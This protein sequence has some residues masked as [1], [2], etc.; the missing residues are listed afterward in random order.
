MAIYHCSAKIISR[1]SG[2]SATGAAAYRAGM[3]ITDERTGLVHDYSRKG[4]VDDSLILAPDHAPSWVHDRAQLWNQVEQAEKRK[5]AQVAREVEVALP[6][7]LSP[8]QMRELVTGY[9]RSQFVDK[10]MIADVNIHHAKSDNPHAHILLTTREISPDGF[11]Q[12]NRDW[13]R[14]ELLQEWREAW[15]IHANKALELAGHE[16][17]IDHRTLEAQ[18]IERVPQIH[19][20]AKVVEM[21]QRGQRTER[22]TRALE[23]EATNAQII[24]LKTYREAIEHERTIQ[25]AAGAERGGISDR[26]RTTSPSLSRTGGRDTP[27]LEPATGSQPAASRGME[28]SPSQNSRFMAASGQGHA[29]SRSSAERGRP[30]RE[31]SREGLD[32]AAMAGGSGGFGNAYSGAADRIVALARPADRHS[33]GGDMAVHETQRPVDRTYLAVRRQLEAMGSES[34]EVGIR[35]PKGRMMIRTWSS[36]EVLK[37]VPWLKRENAKGADIYVRPAGEQNQ[38]LILVDDLNRAQL[39]RMKTAGLE[40]A[41]V[42]ETSPQNYQ[43]WVRLAEHPLNPDV[44]TT[45]SKGIAAHFEADPNSADWRHFGRLAGFTNRKPEHTTETGHNP[46]VLCHGS[47]GQQASRGAELVQKAKQIVNELQ[48]QVERKNRL[49]A[50]KN[51]PEGAFS[52]NPILE[53]QKQLKRLTE[54]YGPS[55]DVSKADYMIGTAM[56]MQGYSPEQLTQALEQASPEL[57]T[58]KAGHEQDYVQRTVRAAFANP[59]VQKHLEAEQHRQ[60]HRS[61]GPSLG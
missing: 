8:E 58:R 41:A 16:Q 55:M 1:S 60:H 12:K 3:E 6:R 39:G 57:P 30:D 61:S 13:N 59:D 52:R 33:G 27:D 51:A 56:A 24:D 46:W 22:G 53:Y 9:A 7:E 4:G 34:Y 21:E 47:S 15:E 10:G 28:P 50:V 2:R 38:G 37:S 26:D 5:D 23:I 29:G 18:G 42:V 45:A 49:E 35:D 48:A 11:G 44:A 54:R 36:D 19:I 25:I 17:R 31:T 14:K 43:A 40:P 20:G 32:L